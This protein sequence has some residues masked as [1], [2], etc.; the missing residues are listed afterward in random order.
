MA[1]NKYVPKDTH[2]PMLNQNANVFSATDR[3]YKWFQCAVF[4]KPR[5][6]IYKMQISVVN[7]D[8]LEIAMN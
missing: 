1:Y 5:A 4:I 8:L 3:I 7:K 2:T 6:V